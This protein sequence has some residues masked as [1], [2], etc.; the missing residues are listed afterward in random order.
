M[1]DAQNNQASISELQES[2]MTVV[3][4][5]LP[6]LLLASSSPRR[7]E[8]LR[9]VGWPFE[10]VPVEIDESLKNGE[11]PETYVERLAL[12]KAQDA[13]V[14]HRNG[15]ILAADTTVVADER[16]LAK[17]T[18]D[19]DAREMLRTL[20]GRWHQVLTGVALVSNQSSRVAHETTEV[21]FAAMSDD[22]IAWYVAT[23]EPMD[24]AGGYAI[25]GL[26]ARFIKE[27][28]GDYFNVMGLPV[29]LV[30]ELAGVRG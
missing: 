22:E 2:D 7:S 18:H 21:R 25:Q 12:A 6:K 23:G 5:K 27:I 17:P 16:I 14:R 13:A 3:E 24:K 29:R 20:Q 19:S 1:E 30:Y 9:I 28:K 8:I 11:S 15:L 10:T 26:G 4:P